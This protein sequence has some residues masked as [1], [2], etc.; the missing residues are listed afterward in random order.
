M[1]APIILAIETAASPTPPV[2]EWISTRS[3]G[4]SRP[5]SHSECQAVR[6]A[7]P[8]VAASP[9]RQRV[10]DGDDE[11]GKRCQVRAECA[12]A[13]GDH[14]LPDL[15]GVNI[16]AD[17]RHEA[18]TLAA[19]HRRGTVE[20]RV[21]A[22]RLEHVAEVEPRGDD[23]NLD[24]TGLRRNPLAP[25]ALLVRPGV[26]VDRSAAGRLRAV[27][28]HDRAATV[29]GEITRRRGGC[30]YQPVDIALSVAKCDFILVRTGEQLLGQG[31]K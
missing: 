28:V 26:R 31:G 20:S 17:S 24:L 19:D 23:T 25:R 2:A 22:H 8:N 15:D 4:D 5:T 30:G 16:V 13:E 18:D 6:Y 1:R 3:P 9:I 12:G 27:Q 7:M 10:G 21:H 11:V 14:A 29:G